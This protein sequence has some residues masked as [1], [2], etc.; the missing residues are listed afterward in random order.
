MEVMVI[1][2]VMAVLADNARASELL[3]HLG[4]RATKFSR[5]C[6]VRAVM[7]NLI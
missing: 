6:L 3:N 5:K 4:S 2:P 7:L 1:A